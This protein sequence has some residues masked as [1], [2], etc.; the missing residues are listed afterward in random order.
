MMPFLPFMNKNRQ[1]R[2]EC[3][4]PANSTLNWIRPSEVS[5]TWP[6]QRTIAHALTSDDRKWLFW[7]QETSVLQRPNNNYMLLSLFVNQSSYLL[8]YLIST[9]ELPVILL[10]AL[11]QKTCTWQECLGRVLKWQL[12]LLVPA[13]I[14]S[15]WQSNA[16][17]N[18]ITVYYK[19]L[20]ILL[21]YLLPVRFRA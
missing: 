3:F 14:S 15:T 5:V 1:R 18:M 13:R 16:I 19:H 10:C 9:R 21:L 8:G 12:K 7:P 11:C 4:E 2:E 6:C 20:Y 17:S